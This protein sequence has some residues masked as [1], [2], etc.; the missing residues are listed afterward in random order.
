MQAAD[1]AG[2]WVPAQAALRSGLLRECSRKQQSIDIAW[3]C[4]ASP[5][6]RRKLL[7]LLV[8]ERSGTP[9]AVDIAELA[10][11]RAALAFRLC[12]RDVWGGWDASQRAN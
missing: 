4:S 11:C 9:E 6:G 7:M 8:L 10:S 5:R 3:G 2:G 1:A 12:V